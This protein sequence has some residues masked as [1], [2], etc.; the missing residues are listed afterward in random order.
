[1]LI[2]IITPVYNEQENILLLIKYIKNY[3]EIYNFKY[4]HIIIDNK[5][6]DDTVSIIHAYMQ[7]CS[8]IILIKN[9]KNYGPDYSPYIGL[10]NSKGDI[11]IPIVADFQDPI[12]TLYEL[13][14]LWYKNRN[15]DV[16][17]VKYK[18]NFNSIRQI[19][20]VLYYIFIKLTS[21]YPEII[22]FQ[23]FGVYSRNFINTINNISY[24]KPF[25]FRGLVSRYAKT[26]LIFDAVRNKRERGQSSYN[27]L[28][29][30]IHG[31][32]GL[33]NQVSIVKLFI[34]SLFLNLLIIHIYEY[35]TI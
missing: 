34:F 35:V 10:I 4:E 27:F 26:I 22:G 5:S 13:I 9:D 31:F 11:A 16:I 7:T 19:M 18:L 28:G 1:M 20:S 32:S 21:R 15:I 8:N 6:T 12:D 24:K 25:Y 2:S 30:L 14:T 23:G 33:Y 17:A 29:L 3:M